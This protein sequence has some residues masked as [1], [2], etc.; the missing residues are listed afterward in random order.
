MSDSR[1]DLNNII[2]EKI[3]DKF[4]RGK[5]GDFDVIIMKK[6]SYINA[7]KLIHDAPGNKQ[8]ADW[9]RGKFAKALMNNVSSSLGISRDALYVVITGGRITKIRGTY[10]HPDLIPHIASWAS[11]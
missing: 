10:V 4:S 3:N 2:F 5:Y 6:N 11:V 7:T 8:L 1:E 9:T